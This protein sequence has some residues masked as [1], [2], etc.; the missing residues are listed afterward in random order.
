MRLVT[1][2]A[3][4]LA[5]AAPA[6]AQRDDPDP[7]PLLPAPGAC[8]H[9]DNA[10]AH[11]RLQRLAMHCL[12]NEVRALTGGPSLDGSVHLRHSATYKA[13]RIADCRSFSHFP[14][15][16]RFASSFRKAGVNRDGR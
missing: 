11:H 4:I 13:R 5:M 14:C 1:T 9:E 8:A 12:L 10:E 6:A 2:A 7:D 16:D 15:G 3:V